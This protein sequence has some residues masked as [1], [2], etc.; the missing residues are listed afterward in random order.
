MKLFF[1]RADE[2][3]QILAR[4]ESDGYLGDINQVVPRTGTIYGVRAE[5]LWARGQGVV[6]VSEDGVGVII[7]EPA[8]EG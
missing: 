8:R 3:V 2:G 7:E 6:E 1:Q 5:D 4:I